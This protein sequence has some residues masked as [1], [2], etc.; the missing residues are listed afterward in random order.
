MIPVFKQNGDNALSVYFENKIDPDVNGKVCALYEDLKNNEI[1]GV[2]ELLP[3]FN[4]LTVFYDPFKITSKSLERKIKKRIGKGVFSDKKIKKTVIIPVCYDSEF[5]LDMD[6]VCSCNSLTSKEVINIHTS[7]DYLIY[8]L[9]FLPGFPYLGGLD[10]RLHTPR[11]KTPRTLIPAGS[12]GIGGNQTGMYPLASPGGWQIIGK[13]PLRLFDSY[14]E[15][16]VF[17]SAGDYIR[18]KEITKAEFYALSADEN[19]VAE[20]IEERL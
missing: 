16:A 9:G 1:R 11:L 8:M 18:F 5:A 13:T 14:R 7:R 3:T 20:I 12:V 15:P 2:C 6:N 17:Y 10:E 4:A 19:A